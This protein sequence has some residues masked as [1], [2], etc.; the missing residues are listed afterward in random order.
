MNSIQ[1]SLVFRGTAK[2]YVLE[3]SEIPT[4]EQSEILVKVEAAGLTP[5]DWKIRDYYDLIVK[6]YPVMLGC[7]VAGIVEAVG[8]NVDNFSIGDRV[9]GV[10]EIRDGARRFDQFVIISA[11]TACKIP[12]LISYDEACTLP[13]GML[14][15]YSGLYAD[16][17][18]GMG[19]TTPVRVEGYNKYLNAPFVVLGGASSVGQCVLQFCRLSGFSPI[20]TT[21]SSEHE[22]A[23]KKLGATHVLRRDLLPAE[24]AHQI[25]VISKVVQFIY[26]AVASKDTQQLAFNLLAPG[27]SA[28]FVLPIQVNHGR[29]DISIAEVYATISRQHN[30]QIY[31][32]LFRVK[33]YEWLEQRLISPNRYEVLPGGL[34]GVIQ[35]L[36]KMEEGYVSR[37]KLMIHPQEG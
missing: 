18:H 22:E 24:L 21:A 33:L 5:S 31:E 25:S 7:D 19:L 1:K 32:E 12:N 4:P 17:P 28:T 16:S 29:T 23:L 26:D 14:T 6:N 20:I 37:M 30:A 10:T 3:E 8:E 9:F 34:N 11:T 2:Q 13:V 15:A 35:G 36:K 27:G